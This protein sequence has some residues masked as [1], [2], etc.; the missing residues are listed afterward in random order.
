MV[1]NLNN[2]WAAQ[3]SETAQHEARWPEF[4]SVT[5]IMTWIQSTAPV[6]PHITVHFQKVSYFCSRIITLRLQMINFFIVN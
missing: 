6:H 2:V 5:Y 1:T 4:K 3:G